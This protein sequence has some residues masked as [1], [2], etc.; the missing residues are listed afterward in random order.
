MTLDRKRA[1]GNTLL[2]I[3]MLLGAAGSAN[4]F[5]SVT[6]YY[7]DQQGT[8]LMT[9]DAQGNQISS[10]DYRPFGQ[11]S[12][13]DSSNGP[14]YTGHM[15]DAD[16]DLIYMQAR[17][18]DPSVGRFLSAD[19]AKGQPGNVDEFNIYS[20]VANNPLR[21][22]DPDGRQTVEDYARQAACPVQCSLVRDQAGQ[23]MAVPTAVAAE[24]FAASELKTNIGSLN[25]STGKQVAQG[26][27]FASAAMSGAALATV[28][29]PPLAVA[30]D[31][32]GT[33]F[34]VV[35]L[36]AEPNAD[37]VVNVATAGLFG[38]A[39]ALAGENKVLTPLVESADAAQKI[40]DVGEQA[41]KIDD[42]KVTN[43]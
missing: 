33:G 22:T 39:K 38:V 24:S 17:Y 42:K 25:Q 19:P 28:E 14:G 35:S 12:L 9:T 16:S 7:T 34:A 21:R 29:I 40:K 11:I 23:W 37:H 5:Q 6:Y 27:D 36:V 30:L 26:T 13:G 20:Y 15:N 4:A 2:A 43:N 1:S 3:S 8:V 41:Q 10:S 31:A 32:I 18:F